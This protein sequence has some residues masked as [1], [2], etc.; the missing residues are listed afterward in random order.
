MINTFI[1]RENLRT[2][3]ENTQGRFVSV[4][5]VKMDNTHRVMNCRFGVRRHLRNTDA[6]TT[7]QHNHIKVTWDANKKNYRNVNLSTTYQVKMDGITY[8]VID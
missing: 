3:L 7:T 2:L 5:F 4:R 8:H 1:K 6:R